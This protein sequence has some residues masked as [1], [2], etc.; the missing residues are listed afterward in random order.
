M[1]AL[2]EPTEILEYSNQEIHLSAHDFGSG[3]GVYLAGVPFTF[4]IA[5]LLQRSLYYAAHQESLMLRGFSTN[6]YCE[7]NIYPELNKYC[8]INN[9][10]VTQTTRVHLD[11]E[12][13]VAHQLAG[14]AIEWR[15][16]K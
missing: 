2:D 15:K 10:A 6:Q 4:D 3:R 16:L 11:E 1:Y 13:T 5:R 14:Y 9:S 8:V 12:R 7:V